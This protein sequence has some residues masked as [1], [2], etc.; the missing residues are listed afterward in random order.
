MSSRTIT[1][2]RLGLSDEAMAEIDDHDLVY[3]TPFGP[4]DSLERQGQPLGDL[5]TTVT[6]NW[7]ADRHV[8]LTN[9]LFEVP[10]V[11]RSWEFSISRHFERIELDSGDQLEWSIHI[12]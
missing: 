12:L 5:P 11:G 2:D 4:E 1:R 9:V 10:E 8:L 3:A 7:R 6:F